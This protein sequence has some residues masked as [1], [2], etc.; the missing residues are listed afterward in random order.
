[1]T[2][3]MGW[4][5]SQC[6]KFLQLFASH[7]V[8]S[9]SKDGEWAIRLQ[10]HRDEGG[11]TDIEIIGP[12]CHII[13]E[14]KRGWNL[15][16]GKQ[17]QRYAARFNGRTQH[18]LFVV[19]SERSEVAAKI[20]LP[21][22]IEGRPVHFIPWKKV[23]KLAEQGALLGNHAEKR[24]L[25]EFIAYLK[26]LLVMQ[27]TNSNLV[28]VVALGSD[29]PS[30]SRY[31]WI[32]IVE[33]DNR[34]FHPS[35]QAGYPH[36]PQNY[37]G[38]RYGGKLQGV[39]HVEKFWEHTDL[40]IYVPCVKKADWNKQAPRPHYIYQLGPRI[41]PLKNV[42]SGPIWNK[43]YSIPIDLLLISDSVDEARAKARQREQSYNN[44]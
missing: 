15:P 6:P 29:T 2:Y 33:K 24:L 8:P 30:W 37:L 12:D 16:N 41:S 34:Y 19:I 32:D 20:D 22:Q 40:S 26:G 17:L 11:F 3:S 4:A 1:M 43:P 27:N 42:K 39:Y 35:N 9:H 31:S 28:Y 14:A 44:E 23:R 10:E 7:I 18:E 21:S 13:I 25:Y 38:F 5:L 36:S